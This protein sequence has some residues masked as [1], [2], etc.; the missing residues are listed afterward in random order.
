VLG[1]LWGTVSLAALRHWRRDHAVARQDDQL[2]ALLA[3]RIPL[4][5]QELRAGTT[6]STN[7]A[8]WT[9]VAGSRTT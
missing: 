9:A 5:R 2:R 8:A 4:P 6:N 7:D 1:S 3:G